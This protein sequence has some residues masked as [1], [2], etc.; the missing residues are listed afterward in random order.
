MASYAADIV[1][2]WFLAQRLHSANILVVPGHQMD[3]ISLVQQQVMAHCPQVCHSDF[4][5]LC[6]LC[7]LQFQ[8]AGF[9]VVFIGNF[10]SESAVRYIV[11]SRR[12]KTPC[13]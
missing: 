8:L 6:R 5:L 12:R 10:S 7:E 4:T 11:E 13:L 3:V 1:A 9:S 2:S